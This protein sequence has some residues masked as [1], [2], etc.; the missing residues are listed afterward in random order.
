MAWLLSVHSGG[1]GPGLPLWGSSPRLARVCG[2]SLPR[3]LLYLVCFS[4]SCVLPG[5]TTPSVA[6]NRLV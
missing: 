1:P 4:L 5:K 2:F 3:S 6:E